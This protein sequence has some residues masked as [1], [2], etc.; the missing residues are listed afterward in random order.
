M[1]LERSQNRNNDN[2]HK[3]LRCYGEMLMEDWGVSAK[4]ILNMEV[5]EKREVGAL[6]RWIENIRVDM[7]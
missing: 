3:R 1:H 6:T 7:I 5:Q 2:I 4:K